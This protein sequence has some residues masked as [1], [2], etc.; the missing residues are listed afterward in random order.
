M[1]W[2]IQEEEHRGGKQKCDNRCV[3]RQKQKYREQ[4]EVERVMLSCFDSSRHLAVSP[5]RPPRVASLYGSMLPPPA[6]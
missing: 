4:I 3:E 6:F 2:T 1:V 5:T